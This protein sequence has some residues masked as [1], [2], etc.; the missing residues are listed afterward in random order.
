M[1]LL[2][3]LATASYSWQWCGWPRE[4]RKTIGTRW[5]E[6]VVIAR[7]WEWWVVVNLQEGKQKRNTEMKRMKGTKGEKQNG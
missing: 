6:K 4:S 1:C 3:V 5:G 7:S 2:V